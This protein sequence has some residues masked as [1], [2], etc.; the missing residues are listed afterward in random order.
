MKCP[1]CH[2]LSFEPESRCRNC[3]FD[4]S[5]EAPEL[6]IKLTDEPEGP[7]ADFDLHVPPG[8]VASFTPMTL[9]AMRQ[10]AD[11]EPAPLRLAA[12]SA[13]ALAE[14]EVEPE[15]VPPVRAPESLRA[16][17]A[18][19]G[20]PVPT[21]ELP[22]FVQGFSSPAIETEEPAL[23]VPPAPPPLSVRRGTV[24][25]PR[26][27]LRESRAPRPAAPTAGD[28]LENLDRPEP[29]TI[30]PAAPAPEEPVPAMPPLQEPAMGAARLA[31]ALLDGLILAVLDLAI[32]WFTLRQCQLT[33]AQ[34]S[35]LP[36]LPLAA[37]FLLV[38]AGYLLM[39][40]AAG[41]QTVGKMAAGIRVIGTEPAESD[42][43]E[44]LEG[45]VTARQAILRALLTV[46]S[47]LA[48]GVGFLPG[49]VGEGRA[50]HDRIAH[51]RVVRA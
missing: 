33:I 3:G 7:F 48:L 10:A 5:V 32:V 31:A 13:T 24:D 1:K 2:Y 19:A 6:N 18:A 46:P 44:G 15:F 11:E 47:V 40:T 42:D 49:L 28:L 35:L 43:E 23:H 45:R 37:F 20:S 41:G 36:L 26:P 30:R 39:F 38:D 9:G 27:K 29:E 50:L 8:R 12:V 4:L 17:P 51:T 34:T 22:L 25:P 21:A 16:V 14:P